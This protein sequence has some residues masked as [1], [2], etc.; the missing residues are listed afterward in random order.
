MCDVTACSRP[1]FVNGLCGLHALARQD[2]GAAGPGA[3][4]R[5]A[6]SSTESV[7]PGRRPPTPDRARAAASAAG[8]A[9]HAGARVF[10]STLRR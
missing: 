6:H 1:T 9:R 8:S 3:R 4:S 2:R 10:S 7:S 5:A